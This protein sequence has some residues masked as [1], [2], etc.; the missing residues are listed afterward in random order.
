MT[1][2][3]EFEVI[4]LILKSQLPTCAVD[5][6]SLSIIKMERQLRK[7]FTYLVFQ[8]SA[9]GPED[10]GSLR[11]VLGASRDAAKN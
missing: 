4:D 7:L 1:F 3:S 11:A 9:F 10:I 2:K 5:A 8:S 6:F